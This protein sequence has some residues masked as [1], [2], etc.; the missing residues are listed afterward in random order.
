MIQKIIDWGIQKYKN[1]QMFY[2]YVFVGGCSTLVNFFVYW[3][4]A[5]HLGFKALTVS[6]CFVPTWFFIR[7]YINKKIVFDR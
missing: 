2:R 4:F 7:Y 6:I 5:D 1:N 3:F